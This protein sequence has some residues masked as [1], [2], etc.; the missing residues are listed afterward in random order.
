M[1]TKLISIFEMDFTPI[2]N[3]GTG[4]EEKTT[5]DSKVRIASIRQRIK[6]V[7]KERLKPEA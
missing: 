3:S 6:W 4:S 5:M 2:R 7:L 1:N